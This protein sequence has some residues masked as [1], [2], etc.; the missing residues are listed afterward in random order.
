MLSIIQ[1]VQSTQL[2]F[3]SLPQPESPLS[4][5]EL[6]ILGVLKYLTDQLL[7]E[8]ITNHNRAALLLYLDAIR[9]VVAHLPVSIVGRRAFLNILWLASVRAVQGEVDNL[10]TDLYSIGFFIETAAGDGGAGAAGGDVDNSGD[11]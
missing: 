11:K 10:K 6:Q 2:V 4:E 5:S 7:P 1:L 8:N 3:A 9:T